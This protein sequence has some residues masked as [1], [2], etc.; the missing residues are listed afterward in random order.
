MIPRLPPSIE[1][2]SQEFME[3]VNLQYLHQ[4]FHVGNLYDS[5]RVIEG[6]F[7][8]TLERDKICGEKHW[9]VGPFNPVEI[10]PDVSNPGHRH[11]C[12]QWLDKQ[13]ERS[14]IYVSFGTT[15]TFTESQIRELAIGLEN[16]EQMFLWVVRDADKGDVFANEVGRR[17]VLPEGFEDRVE[18]RGGCF[19]G[20]IVQSVKVEKVV[21]KLMDTKEG[22]AVRK[23]AA[24]LG[25]ELR[26]SL[27]EDLLVIA[28][29]D[30][31]E[32]PFDYAI[33]GSTSG[34]GGGVAVAA[35]GCGIEPATVAAA[36][37][38]KE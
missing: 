15:T 5:S 20:G 35:V 31:L 18:G 38:K 27:A 11:S 17:V 9:A 36:E 8:E 24:E 7:L 14:V 26:M 4:T 13:P 21:R 25:G 12:L 1:T 37:S 2:M 22:A 33:N 32:E 3:F 23:R 29:R 34:G 19:E 6:E 30:A 10:Q 28:N 16:S